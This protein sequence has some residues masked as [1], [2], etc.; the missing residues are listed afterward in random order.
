[1][2]INK[3]F[4]DDFLSELLPDGFSRYL[5]PDDFSR[6]LLLGCMIVL[7]NH[8]NPVRLNLFAAGV[9]ELFTHILHTFAPEKEVRKCKWFVQDKGTN[10]ITRMQRVMYA[11]Q[12]GFSDN[13]ISDF[14]A[15]VKDLQKAAIKTMDALNKATHVKPETVVR[16]QDK[17]DIF[18][19]DTLDALE[20][21]LLSISDGRNAVKNALEISV[22]D[23]MITELLIQ[24]FNSI[25]ELA[26]N[27]YWVE[28]DVYE[29]EVVL[30]KI[31]SEKVIVKFSGI[32]PVVLQYGSR[33]DSAE[34]PHDFPFW[35]K[36]EATV[37]EPKKLKLID[38]FFDDSS[39]HS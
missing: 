38:H 18:V 8:S 7:E 22:Y 27:G 36:F 32:A 24:N 4:P 20:G 17:I 30:E 39:W 16:D 21:L 2:Y 9:R 33:D 14:S 10:S 15:N 37:D 28:Q 19:S 11:T 35:M 1:M 12:G 25:S 3:L 26:G 23:S 31:T 6:D 13:Y 29:Y 34:I 5:L